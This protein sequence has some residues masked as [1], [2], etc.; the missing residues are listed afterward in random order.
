M[1]KLFVIM[2]LFL[3]GC[4]DTDFAS[5]SAIG[6]AAEITCY[7]GDK[8]IFEGKSTGRVQ[9]VSHSDGWE[10]K[11]AATGKFIRVSGPCVIKN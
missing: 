3:M 2:S 9:T 6:N 11:D 10:F 8:I 7:S 4:T 1:K 5:F